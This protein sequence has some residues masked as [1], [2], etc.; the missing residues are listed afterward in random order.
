LIDAHRAAFEYDW[1]ARFRKPLR[2]V[3]RSMTWGE[4][5]RLTMRLARDTSSEVGASLA[6]WQYPVSRQA[7]AI[8][9]LYDATANA[10]FKKPKPYPRPWDPAPK[11]YGN[12]SLSITEVRAVLNQH[13]GMTSHKRDANGRL[14]DTRGRFVAEVPDQGG[15]VRR[16]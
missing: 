11:R 12:A 3:G 2:I 4:A 16:G 15:D 10:H 14:R 5:S 7:L 8:F 6:G 1:R 9:D 13:R